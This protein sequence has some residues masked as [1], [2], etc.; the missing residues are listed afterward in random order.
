[1]VI[2]PC[3]F[4]SVTDL[5]LWVCVKDKMTLLQQLKARLSEGT[6]LPHYSVDVGLCEVKTGL[7][8]K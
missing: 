2:I 7:I 6:A 1:M 4:F 8:L 3:P 5:F